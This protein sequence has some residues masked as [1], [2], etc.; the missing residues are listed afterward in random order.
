[1]VGTYAAVR[2]VLPI[3]PAWVMHNI[4]AASLI[5]SV[6]PRDGDC[7]ERSPP[8]LLL[9][10]SE[11]FLTDIRGARDGSAHWADWFAGGVAFGRGGHDGFGLT[12]RSME[13]RIGRISLPTTTACTSTRRRSPFLPHYTGLAS[14]GFRCVWI[15]RHGTA[16]QRSGRHLSLRG[17]DRGDRRSAQRHCHRRGVFQAV[18]PVSGTA[19]R[20]HWEFAARK[21]L[22]S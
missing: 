18:Y 21:R 2:L 1:M 17:V 15:R 13:S 9:P 14:I 4:A 20:S 16:H 8:L 7:S 5:T 3:A 6:Y 10:A 22:L 12:L 11:P 19:R